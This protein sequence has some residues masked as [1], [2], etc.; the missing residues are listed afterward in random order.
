MNPTQT[1]FIHCQPVWTRRGR[2][3]RGPVCLVVASD[4][5]SSRT[6]NPE[7]TK[8]WLKPRGGTWFLIQTAKRSEAC[9]SWAERCSVT[10]PACYHWWCPRHV[11]SSTG[12]W[13]LHTAS[14]F[15]CHG[16]GD[17]SANCRCYLRIPSLSWFAVRQR[18]TQW[19]TTGP[20]RETP[21]FRRRL[22]RA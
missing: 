6:S 20:R 16:F 1:S 8:L 4:R 17:C 15:P 5:F 12:W 3:E 21:T 7:A 11:K 10:G 9:W 19:S 18:N 13:G 2:N 14:H 22:G